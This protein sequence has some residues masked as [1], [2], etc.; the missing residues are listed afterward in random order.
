MISKNYIETL[1]YQEYLELRKLLGVNHI[2]HEAYEFFVSSLYT[3]LY[4]GSIDG[5]NSIISLAKLFFAKNEKEASVIEKIFNDSLLNKFISINEEIE[6]IQSKVQEEIQELEQDNLNN[7]NNFQNDQSS[8]E[9]IDVND[10][11]DEQNESL[12]SEK[13]I[14]E[15]NER[16][17]KKRRKETINQWFDVNLH[18]SESGNSG[19][20]KK[21]SVQL[22]GNH[23]MLHDESIMPFSIRY[24]SQ[25]SRK[26]F[27]TNNQVNNKEIDLP[28]MVRAYCSNKFFDKIIYKRGAINQSNIVLLSD[29]FGSMLSYEYLEEHLVHSFK[30]IPECIFEHYFFYNLPEHHNLLT[31][32][33]RYYQ[34]NNSERGKKPLL[35]NNAKWNKD[36]TFIIFSDAGAHSGVVKKER[37]KASIDFWNHL[38]KFSRKIF[39]LNPVPIREMN[40]C[41]AK[42]LNLYIKMYEPDFVGFEKLFKKA[43]TF[44]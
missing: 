15:Q 24:L 35:T 17:E 2:S 3:L 27:Q 41:T 13:S 22:D 25:K 4:S 42:R 34:F 32:N 21:L 40:D 9:T 39:W 38:V 8:I 16:K 6:L 43:A 26:A 44:A 36:T 30:I 31:D 33:N 7:D 19:K 1:F 11:S 37:I 18:L 12:T 29:R 5:K 23:F 28:A 14:L 20:S 10:S